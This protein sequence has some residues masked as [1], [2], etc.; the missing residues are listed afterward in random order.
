MNSVER[1]HTAPDYYKIMEPGFKT[2]FSC[3]SVSSATTMNFAECI[4]TAPDYY[5]IM[6]TESSD[7]NSENDFVT[8]IL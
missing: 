4:H 6:G 5:R 1:M 3:D 8:M 7:R 2:L